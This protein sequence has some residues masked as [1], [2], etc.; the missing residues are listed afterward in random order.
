MLSSRAPADTGALAP[1]P[2]P[3]LSTVH[4]ERTTGVNSRRRKNVER[5]S[6]TNS[7]GR[8]V[9]ALYSCS[10]CVSAPPAASRP[11]PPQL[12]CGVGGV[13]SDGRRCRCS[14]GGGVSGRATA[15][16]RCGATRR[17]EC[18]L[19]VELVVPVRRLLTVVTRVTSARLLD[20]SFRYVLQDSSVLSVAPP[21]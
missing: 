4:G 1:M 13:F 21:Q 12:G 5:S 20:T 16:L 14:S 3:L 19:L 17:D 15:L 2:C 10:S 11:Q 6:Y 9:S 8:S 18:P 7:R